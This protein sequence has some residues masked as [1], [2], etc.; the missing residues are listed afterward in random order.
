MI[1]VRPEGSGEMAGEP[2]LFEIGCAG[3]VAEHQRSADGRFH[4]LLRATERFRVLRELPREPGR[5]YR[6]AEIEPL[7]EEVGDAEEAGQARDRVL[8]LL[9]RLAE[10]RIGPQRSIDSDSLRAL[11]LAHFAVDVLGQ[12]ISPLVAHRALLLAVSLFP[13]ILPKR[14]PGMMQLRLRRSRYDAQ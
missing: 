13:E 12:S 7:P 2:P 11:G 14:H 3:F 4:L 8:H 1:A 6:V 9:V 5:L 10:R